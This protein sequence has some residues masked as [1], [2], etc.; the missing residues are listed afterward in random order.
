MIEN[1]KRSLATHGYIGDTNLPVL[2][3]LT[4]VSALLDNPVSLLIKGPAS[5]GKSFALARAKRFVPDDAYEQFEGMSE[6]SL[7]YLG[8]QL[9]LRHK[10]L[11][12]QEAAGTAQGQGQI[13]L[14]QLLTEGAIR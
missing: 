2:I 6:R 1:L 3:Y 10:T 9:D 13:F 14:R 11:I 12:I 5:S 8:D 4:L 7:V